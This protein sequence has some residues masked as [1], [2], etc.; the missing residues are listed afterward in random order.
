MFGGTESHRPADISSTK[1]THS[2]HWARTSFERFA[3]LEREIGPATG[4]KLVSGH[5]QSDNKA[6]LESQV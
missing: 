4:V 3:K 6:N 5:I 1:C 2:R